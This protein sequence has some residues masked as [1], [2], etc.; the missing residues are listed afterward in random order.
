MVTQEQIFKITDIITGKIR[1]EQI[2]LFGSYVDGH[3][4]EDSDVDLLIVKDTNLPRHNRTL[5]IRK[6]LR[7]MKI[8]IDIIVYNNSEI[9]KWKKLKTSFIYEVLNTGKVLYD[10]KERTG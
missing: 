9:E 2:I 6:Y 8:P 1:P 3:P 5:E 10:R 7:G 4:N